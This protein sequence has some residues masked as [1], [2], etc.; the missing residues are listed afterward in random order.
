MIHVQWL[1]KAWGVIPSAMI[2]YSFKKCGISN[3]L[4]G[5]DDNI[6]FKDV[7]Q[8]MRPWSAMPTTLNET[9][10]GGMMPPCQFRQRSSTA[11][12][13]VILKDFNYDMI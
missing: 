9:R 1:V 13:K 10:I 7:C 6:M 12:T 4:D 2:E 5:T 8:C 11:M 3:N